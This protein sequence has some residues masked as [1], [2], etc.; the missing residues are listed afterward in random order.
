MLAVGFWPHGLAEER[1]DH[2]HGPSAAGLKITVR[3]EFS[4]FARLDF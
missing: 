2:F 4:A 3:S 1:A